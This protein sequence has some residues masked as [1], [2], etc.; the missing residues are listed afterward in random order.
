MLRWSEVPVRLSCHSDTIHE[1]GRAT[2]IDNG[3]PTSGGGRRTES[4]Y[5][6]YSGNREKQQ[7][8]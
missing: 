6:Q 1:R 7:A 5:D 4:I 2:G 8:W 3:L